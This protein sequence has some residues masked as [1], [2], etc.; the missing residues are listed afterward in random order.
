MC[1]VRFS[2]SAGGSLVSDVEGDVAVKVNL[3]LFICHRGDQLVVNEFADTATAHY[4][5]AVTRENVSLVNQVAIGVVPAGLRRVLPGQQAHTP[6]QFEYAGSGELDVVATGHTQL[7]FTAGTAATPSGY[8]TGRNHNHHVFQVSFNLAPVR[9]GGLNRGGRAGQGGDGSAGLNRLAGLA[10]CSLGSVFTQRHQ[11]NVVTQATSQVSLNR[12]NRSLSAYLLGAQLN[13]LVGDFFSG[14][15]AYPGSLNSG[16]QRVVT[17]HQAGATHPTDTRVCQRDT[18]S[19][20][21]FAGPA[22]NN[23]VQ[24]ALDFTVSTVATEGTAVRRTRQDHVQTV[25]HIG[26]SANGA[27]G[28]N[29]AL[30]APQQQTGLRLSL[31]TGVGQRT[32]H[33]PSSEGEQQGGHQGRLDQG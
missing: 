14:P 27:Q 20:L 29:A 31:R 28:S 23:G 17:T 30:H 15:G 32:G 19:P 12:L 21:L 33:T 8:F 1:R 13:Q 22:V 6:G 9:R 7:S 11:V 24:S 4:L 16:H 18:L 5:V 3:N 25:V 2:D 10:S 26:V